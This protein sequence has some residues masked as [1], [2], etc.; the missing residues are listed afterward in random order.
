MNVRYAAVA[1]TGINGP[2]KKLRAIDDQ[3][4]S[5]SDFADAKA[6]TV[7]RAHI[8][9]DFLE[10]SQC[11]YRMHSVSGA[12]HY[13]VWFEYGPDETEEVLPFRMVLQVRRSGTQSVERRGLSARRAGGSHV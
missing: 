2:A 11:G 10:K 13:E 4:A 3:P 5:W 6:A 1:E 9:R 7:A 12:H 8:L